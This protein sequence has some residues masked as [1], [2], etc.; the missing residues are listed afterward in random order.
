MQ[1]ES[2][3]PRV[4][5][6]PGEPAGIGPD[7]VIA[8]AQQDWPVELVCCA[9]PE[10]LFT[11]ALQLS[12]PLTLRDYQP[13]QPAQP[14]QAGSLTVLPIATPAT[15][16]AGQ[17][18]V[19]N[20]A[21]VVETLARACDGCLNGEF[22]ALIT[23]PVHK[24]IIN[25]AGVPFS[26]HTEFF[27]DRSN[28]DRVVMML[29]TEELRVAL[30]T[31]HLPLAAVSAAITRQSLHEVITI[32]HHDLQKKFGITQPQIYVCG[33]NPHAGEGGHMGREELDVINPALDELRQQG[34]TLIGPLPADTLFQPKYLQHADAVLAMYH[35]QGLPVL[36]YQGFGR[37][38]NIT[39]GL[40][41]IRTSVDHGTALELAATGNADPGSFITALNLAIKMIKNSN[42]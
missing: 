34:I 35:D 41:F 39:L 14:Q 27:A 38:V 2:N 21:Y 37:A 25:D 42:E 6:T 10:L 11:R 31:T 40:P 26:G 7:L 20:S 3:T 16:I 15:V 9:D 18:N 8:L 17:L 24:G 4:V 22:A 12:M 5:I 30:A 29:A 33:L 1:T 19:A 36:K 32:L 28:C 23:G 13:G